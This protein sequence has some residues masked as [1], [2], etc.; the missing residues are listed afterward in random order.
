MGDPEQA[1]VFTMGE[2]EAG[3]PAR[4]LV[5]VD[6]L[7]K[8][9]MALGAEK[10]KS[11]L[12]TITRYVDENFFPDEVAAR[13]AKV[14]GEFVDFVGGPAEAGGLLSPL[15]T[16]CTYDETAVREA[17]VASINAIGSKMS[18][19]QL[20]EKLLPVFEFLANSQDWWA[21]RVSACGL[22]ALA[23]SAWAG[24][25]EDEKRKRIVDTFRLLCGHELAST[26]ASRE[27][28]LVRSA[29]AAQLGS[30]LGAMADYATKSGQGK[31][32]DVYLSDREKHGHNVSEF[33]AGLLNDDHD[34]VK[35]AA[36]KSSAAVFR[37][38][39]LDS[40]LG[41]KFKA[42]ATDKSW[43]VRVAVAEVL[44]EVVAATTSAGALGREIC[45]QL[46]SD[47]EAEVKHAIAER[48]ALVAKVL[49]EAFAEDEIFPRL[50]ALLL[51]LECTIRDKL[52]AVLMDMA[53]PLGKERATNLILTGGLFSLLCNDENT[54]VRLAVL[55]K[56]QTRFLEVVR[57]AGAHQA[58]LF[59]TLRPLAGSPNWRV[60]HSVLMLMPKI[61]EVLKEDEPDAFES[62]FDAA[63]GFK[64]YFN[65]ENNEDGEKT[66]QSKYGKTINVLPWALDPIAEIRKEFAVV[67]KQVGTVFAGSA[68]PRGS[69][70][71]VWL[72]EKVLP[73]LVYC[74]SQKEFKDKYHQR[75]ILLLGL[76]EIAGFLPE[77]ELESKLG[78]VFEMAREKLEN[79]NYVPSLRLMIARDLWKVSSHVSSAFLQKELLP[80]LEEMQKDEDPDVRAFAK[81]SQ[82]TIT[83]RAP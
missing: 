7:K 74:C 61:V 37:Y 83:A 63:F 14:L 35:V 47:P 28:P 3:S 80:L 76:A 42:C 29:A 23:Y 19:E 77:A 73:V 25:G 45:L 62:K 43:R 59:E 82:A 8:I 72:T 78:L 46:M 16:L 20:Q 60:R 33:Y 22:I 30:I 52:A 27:N 39:P 26:E 64:F 15:Q 32:M 75:V 12:K 66:M 13:L 53:G 56:L 40:P 6:N 2:L 4:A 48:S 17:A 1:L 49:G 18:P 81:S 50:K 70:G 65:S 34:Y 68:P 69:K 24:A 54:N 57:V 10:F 79:G 51:P 38:W 67:C 71:G 5:V 41:Q 21:P 36:V 31:A 55:N 58:D 11:L 44:S 9:S